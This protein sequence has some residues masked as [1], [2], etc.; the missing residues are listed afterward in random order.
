MYGLLH[1]G[2]VFAGL[3]MAAAAW[4]GKACAQ[5]VQEAVES[6]APT[7]GAGT[8][9]WASTD[10]EGTN[11]IKLVGRALW[12][13]EGKDDYAGIAVEQ[14]WFT[15]ATGAKKEFT[16]VYADL[17]NKL[18][19]DWRWRARVGTD[20][21]TLL[22]SAEIRRADWSR[23]LFIEREIIETDQGL[24]RNIY[25]TFA[26]ASTDIRVDESNSLAVTAGIQEFSG[27]NERFHLR[28]RFVHVLKASAG[29][30]A[31]MDLRYYH[32]TEPDEFDYFSPANF[33][34][35]MPIVQLRR[36]DSD[37]WMYLAAVGF[38]AQRSTG[39]D[40]QPARFA[41][42]RVESPRSARRLDAFAEVVYTNDSIVGGLNYD[43]LQGRLGV[44]MV[45]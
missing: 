3:A 24:S 9:I 5:A 37:G 8:E 11:V 18:S 20:G 38:G 19:D 43:Y 40:W 17:A 41:Q 34:R 28:G 32:S 31:H 16:R 25:Y 6:S 2:I 27:K 36:F 1:P 22:G 42:L 23:T 33:V 26:G 13:F 39:S 29:L 10:S 15:P 35:A 7:P 45:F 21:T 14:A 4:P 30:S 12:D 44:T